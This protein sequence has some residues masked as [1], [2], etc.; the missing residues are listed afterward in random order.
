MNATFARALTEF[1]VRVRV[2][3]RVSSP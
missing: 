2:R 3:V 1:P